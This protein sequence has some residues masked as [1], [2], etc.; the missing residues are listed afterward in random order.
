M[1]LAC[2]FGKIGREDVILITASIEALRSTGFMGSFSPPMQ[3]LDEI[4]PP[5]PSPPR[6][7]LEASTRTSSKDIVQWNG[8]RLQ[9]LPPGDPADITTAPS[10]ENYKA[11]GK[12]N[13]RVPHMNIRNGSVASFTIPK[14]GK[15]SF[16]KG[17]AVCLL[18]SIDGQCQNRIF[19]HPY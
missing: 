19:V 12:V 10:F 16:V 17:V 9:W 4:N 6:N 11:S 3:V 18:E 13:E 8:C 2:E 15:R 7:S 14:R 5:P 1:H